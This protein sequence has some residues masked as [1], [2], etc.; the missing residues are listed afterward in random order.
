MAEKKVAE[1]KVA[2]RI[3]DLIKDLDLEIFALPNQTVSMHCK[4]ED[5]L[6]NEVH[7]VLK[8]TAVLPAL[9]EA[10]RKAKIAK[11]EAWEISQASRYTILKLV[12]KLY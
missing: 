2:D 9:E 10:L 5:I 6:P 7:L 11:N 3:W 1:E 12:P 4:R 8:S